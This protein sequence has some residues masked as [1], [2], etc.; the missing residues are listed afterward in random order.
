MSNTSLGV[1]LLG[2]GTVGGGVV[3]ILLK[4]RELLHQRTGIYFDLKHVAVKGPEDY[5]P[6]AADLPMSTDANACID[7]P[8]SQVIIELIGGT[9]VAHTFVQRALSLGKPVIT[10]N[11][12]L[13]AAKGP[14]LFALARSKNTCIAFEASAGGGI[15]IID[16]LQRGLIANRVDALLGIVN[17]TCNY[18]LTQMTRQGQS[19]ADAL[20]DAQ[21]QGFAEANPTMDVTG[22]DAQQKLSILAS[23]AFNCRVDPNSIPT[24]GIDQL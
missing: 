19:Y 11:K 23:L 8:A 3:N 22:K 4:Q 1:A 16:A 17:G 20:K 9:G 2:C 14:E 13:L 6:N 12:A 10:A 5:P 7:D 21:K 18:I 24:Q 15:P